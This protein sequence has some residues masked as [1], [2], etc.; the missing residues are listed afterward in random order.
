MRE[1]IKKPNSCGHFSK[2]VGVG[3]GVNLVNPLTSNKKV[4]EVEKD[5]ECSET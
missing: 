1:G 2:R 4:L 3:G 5:E